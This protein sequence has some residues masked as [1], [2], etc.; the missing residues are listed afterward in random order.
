[1]LNVYKATSV[2]RIIESSLGHT[3]PWV[4]VV[5]TNNSLKKYVV[6]LYTTDQIE[7][8]NCLSSEVF[9]NVLAK[10]FDLNVPEIALID[11]S[12]IENSLAPIFSKQYH[13]VDNRL[14][15]GTLE[16][17][18][19]QTFKIGLP[20]K[21]IKT[22]IEIDTLYAFDNL[23]RNADRGNSKPNLLLSKRNA[24]LIDHEFAL[25]SKNIL[26]LDITQKDFAFEE[27]YTQKHIFHNYLLK[28]KK[29][30]IKSYFASFT[31]YLKICNLGKLEKYNESL[32]EHDFDTN[33]KEITN[34]LT[35][36]KDNLYKFETILK[37]SI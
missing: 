25:Q 6:K 1:M 33:L 20:K 10:E 5:E 2:E 21:S 7:N 26:N 4:V 37:E 23:I 29:K 32:K 18:P 15:F 3:K 8:D 22:K 36:V 27:K 17:Y 34:W 24:Y 14:K 12:L 35:H 16:I 31:E 11:F 30:D 19:S 13:E 9:C 28:N